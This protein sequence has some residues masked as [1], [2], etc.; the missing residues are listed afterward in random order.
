[1]QR[2]KMEHHLS[3]HLVSTAASIS[4][5]EISPVISVANGHSVS[6]SEI[7]TEVKEGNQSGNGSPTSHKVEEAVA[8]AT[9]GN[10]PTI[11]KESEETETGNKSPHTHVIT[12]APRADHRNIDLKVT[13]HSLPANSA[14][15]LSP[16]AT[17]AA[18]VM[19]V[20]GSPP[21][22]TNGSNIITIHEMSQASIVTGDSA[23]DHLAWQQHQQHGNARLRQY[24]RGESDQQQ[25]HHNGAN[26]EEIIRMH[27]GQSSPRFFVQ[28][29]LHHR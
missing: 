13:S 5:R 2:I 21:D 10:Q 14:D 24:E 25:L 18:T 19:P 15:S 3:Q 11:K 12:E 9:S 6:A 4:E 1:M 16:T 7:K 22:A 20:Q 28:Q 17:V 8:S 23:A 29:Q 26:S 27:S